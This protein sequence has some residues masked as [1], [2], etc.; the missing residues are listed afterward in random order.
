MVAHLHTNLPPH[1]LNPRATKF[2]IRVAF[3][4]FFFFFFTACFDFSV[5]NSTLV[6]YSRVSQTSFFSN[7]FIKNGSHSTIH[8]FKNYFAT[9]FSV[10]SFQFQQNKFYPNGYKPRFGLHW[11]WKK[12]VFGVFPVGLM[13]CSRDPQVQKNANLTLKTGSQG[14]IH[15]FINYFVTVFLVF[16]FQ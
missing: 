6:Y 15:T 2:W 7:F 5:V 9:V 13:H 11:K 10:F 4:F 8:T 1:Q 3:L 16:N 12:I 14:I